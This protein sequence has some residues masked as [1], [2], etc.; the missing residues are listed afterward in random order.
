MAGVLKLAGSMDPAQ[1]AVLLTSTNGEGTVYLWELPS[2]QVCA[3]QHP[4]LRSPASLAD[5]GVCACKQLQAISNQRH[6]SDRE[7]QGMS[8]CM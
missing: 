5:A 7:D 3:C 2:F 8:S 4:K 1:T 6:S